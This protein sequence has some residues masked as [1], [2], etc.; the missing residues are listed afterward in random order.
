MTRFAAAFLLAPALLVACSPSTPESDGPVLS[1]E[2]AFI[3]APIA[4]RDVTM[5][6]IDI[7]VKGGDVTMT[8]AISDVAETLET[9]TMTMEDGTMRMRPVEH[10]E[11][12]DGE[13][14]TLERGG[15]HLMMFGLVEGLSAGETANISFS[16]ETDDGDALT[17]EAEAEVRAPGQ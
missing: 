9:H 6:G 10:F 8:G 16:F 3:M 17:L 2:N 14:L 13:T 12:A 4:G 1:Y 11:I 15:N 7:S 5:G